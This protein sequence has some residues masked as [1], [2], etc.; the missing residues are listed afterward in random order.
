[1]LARV[2]LD[3]PVRGARHPADRALRGDA[4]AVAHRDRTRAHAVPRHAH[5]ASATRATCSGAWPPRAR[6]RWAP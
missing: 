1:M 2:A 5:G 3:V 4:L 6:A